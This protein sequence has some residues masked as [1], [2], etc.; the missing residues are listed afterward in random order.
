[1]LRDE[2]EFE[3][4]IEQLLEAAIMQR[5]F[6]ATR[7]Q[8]WEDKKAEVIARIKESGINVT[9]SVANELSNTSATAKYLS[10]QSIRGAQILID[11]TMQDD[12]NECTEKIRQHLQLRNQYAAWVQVFE[13]QPKTSTRKLQHDDWMFFFGK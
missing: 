10:T 2:W 13:A 4:T 11:P 8:V 9:D 3:Y 1:M 5:D 6:R 12:L 7:V